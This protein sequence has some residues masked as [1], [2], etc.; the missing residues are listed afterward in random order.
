MK[1]V[2]RMENNLD[3]DIKHFIPYIKKEIAANIQRYLEICQTFDN[4]VFLI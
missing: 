1:Y 4:E 2:S 3:D